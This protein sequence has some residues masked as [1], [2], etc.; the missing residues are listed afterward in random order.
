MHIAP[1]L[2]SQSD[3][4]VILN[5]AIGTPSSSLIIVSDTTNISKRDRTLR[6]EEPKELPC[7]SHGLFRTVQHRAPGIQPQTARVDDFHG[8]VGNRQL[9]QILDV[10][11]ALCT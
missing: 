1:V 3:C 9:S 2:Q 7:N 4:E 8:R 10:L 6:L 5:A 11:K